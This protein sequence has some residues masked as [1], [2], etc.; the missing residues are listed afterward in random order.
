MDNVC[1]M[2]KTESRENCPCP[3]SHPPFL[4]VA[5]RCTFVLLIQ[6][7]KKLKNTKDENIRS[8]NQGTSF[9]G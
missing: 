2:S 1:T 8:T 4:S 6:T 5:A 3:C 9:A 7:Q